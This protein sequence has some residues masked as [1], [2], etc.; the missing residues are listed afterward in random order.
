MYT[1]LPINLV[2]CSN[3]N[4]TNRVYLPVDYYIWPGNFENSVVKTNDEEHLQGSLDA[5]L[6][7]RLNENTRKL[8]ERSAKRYWGSR[9]VRLKWR[10]VQG[11]RSK[12]ESH[13]SW[14]SRQKEHEEKAL[15]SPQRIWTQPK[16]HAS[17]A[18]KCMGVVLWNSG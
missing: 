17:R 12:L 9:M 18:I 6:E 5:Y 14:E 2:V 10:T 4:N 8:W 11:H 13:N 7:G 16:D 3:C 15:L 1:F